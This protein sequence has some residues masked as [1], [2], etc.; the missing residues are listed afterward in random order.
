MDT[1]AGSAPEQ[2]LPKRVQLLRRLLLHRQRILR[3][4]AADQRGRRSDRSE[5]QSERDFPTHTMRL[6]EPPGPELLFAD[7]ARAPQAARAR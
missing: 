4:S 6:C 1:P 5:H 7:I 2:I 3:F